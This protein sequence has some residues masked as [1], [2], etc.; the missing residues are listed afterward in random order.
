[1]NTRFVTVCPGPSKPCKPNWNLLSQRC[2]GRLSAMTWHFSILSRPSRRRHSSFG[3]RST[4]CMMR[5]RSATALIQERWSSFNADSR[6]RMFAKTSGRG[7]LN[8]TGNPPSSRVFTFPSSDLSAISK[9]SVAS[10]SKP[11]LWNAIFEQPALASMPCQC[12]PKDPCPMCSMSELCRPT[13]N[14]R[15]PNQ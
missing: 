9:R 12:S 4:T 3:L 14:L 8:R 7:L 11:Q 5:P 2:L 10:K 1:M 13:G 6:P 15:F